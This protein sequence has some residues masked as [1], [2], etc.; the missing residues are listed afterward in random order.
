MSNLTFVI[1]GQKVDVNKDIDFTR[2]YRGGDTVD[3]KKNNYSLTVKFPF[4]YNNDL[5]FKRANSLSY[6]STFSYDPHTCDVSS[7]GVVLISKASL[8]LLSTTDCYECSM[9]WEDFDII[10][11]VLNNPIKLGLLLNEFPLLNWNF[12]DALCGTAYDTTKA[13]TYGLIEYDSGGSNYF[14]ETSPDTMNQ[15]Y[16]LPHPVI[17]YFYLLNEVFTALGIT[18]NI[19]T[20]K[21]D[22]LK[23]L[24]IRPNKRLNSYKNNNFTCCFNY[25][26]TFDVNA[27]IFMVPNFKNVNYLGDDKIIGNNSFYF[28]VD[29]ISPQGEDDAEF[30]GNIQIYDP[31]QDDLV[32]IHPKQMYRVNCLQDCTATI[33]ISPTDFA[34]PSGDYCKIYK[35]NYL[36]SNYVLLD[37]FGLSDVV[38]DTATFVHDIKK[39]DFLV[40]IYEYHDLGAYFEVTID[41]GINP[42]V[43]NISTPMSFPSLFHIPSCIDLSSGQLIT[44]ALKLTGSDLTYDVNSDTYLFSEKI[45]QNQTAYDITKNVT[46]IKEITYDTKYLFNTNLGQN[47]H[48][49]YL[50]NSPINGDYNKTLANPNLAVNIYQLTSLFSTSAINTSGTFDDEAIVHENDTS[51]YYTHYFIYGSTFYYN[52]FIEQPLHLFWND[53][54]NSRVVYLPDELNWSVI[55]DLFYIDWFSDLETRILS[56]TVRLLKLNAEITDIEFKR[57]NTKGIVYLKTFGKFYSIIEVAKNGDF[58]EFFILELY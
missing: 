13:D 8:V 44:E 18:V 57:I 40:F 17:N 51:T 27:V 58:A 32:T 36:T 5:V 28:N 15:K 25:Y 29:V 1:D 30:L 22:F 45:K 41:V 9:T 34:L 21:E 12:E 33:T 37:Q 14:Y 43:M 50:T 11:A 46:E 6:K 2:I 16:N 56:G 38:L 39:N 24:I 31:V 35:F 7:Y 54:A 48:Y 3:V 53:V 4:T 52:I 42:D 19:P 20:V 23:Q 26:G 49:K 10:G 47:N 55:F